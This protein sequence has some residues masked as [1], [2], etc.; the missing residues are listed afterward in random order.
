MRCTYVRSLLI[1]RSVEF[2]NVMKVGRAFR[3]LAS[4]GVGLSVPTSFRLN[5]FR[6]T[7]CSLP[8]LS[9][10]VAFSLVPY[11]LSNPIGASPLSQS[12]RALDR[13]QSLL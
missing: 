1:S 4:V 8:H 11:L 6:I 12:C 5:G 2:E 10:C 7:S 3:V 9:L 13:F